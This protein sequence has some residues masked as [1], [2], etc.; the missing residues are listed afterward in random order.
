MSSNRIYIQYV[1]LRPLPR[2]LEDMVVRAARAE[3]PDLSTSGLNT[4]GGTNFYAL[5]WGISYFIRGDR[6]H[7]LKRLEQVYRLLG[8]EAKIPAVEDEPEAERLPVVYEIPKG[9]RSKLCDCG[10]R[11]WFIKTPAG[12]RMPVT[13]DGVSHFL[14]CKN[15]GK[16]SRKKPAERKAA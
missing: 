7:A 2:H 15:A 9:A 10:T 6:E 5:T 14:T 3:L 13:Q 1:P 12:E 8:N 4:P 16:H 11:I